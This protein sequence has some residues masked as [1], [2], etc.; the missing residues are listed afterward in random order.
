M[1]RFINKECYVY[2]H[3]REEVLEFHELCGQHNLQYTNRWRAEQEVTDY[4][5]QA[6][7]ALDYDGMDG[8]GV[9]FWSYNKGGDHE[10]PYLLFSEINTH[11][12]PPEINTDDFMSIL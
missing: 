10:R 2:C 12:G 7:F 11:T 4:I 3:T 5:E 8:D 1:E 6:T 9:S